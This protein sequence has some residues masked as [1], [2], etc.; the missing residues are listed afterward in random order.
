MP[1]KRLPP[2]VQVL[3]RDRA[4]KIVRG[5]RGWATV[6]DKRVFG[7]TRDTAEKAH[8]DA[9]KMRGAGVEA[10]VWTGALKTRAEEW[11]TSIAA[12]VSA[13]TVD[14]YRGKLKNIYRTIPESMPVDR[15]TSAI[16]R[17]FVREA[18]EK[19][20]LSARTI[21]HC[22]RT[23]NGLFTWMQRRGFLH[24]NPTV[25]VEWPKPVDT[26]PDALNEVELAAC[27]AKI[28]DPWARDLAVFMAFTGLRRSEVARL[29]LANVDLTNRVLWVHGKS[30]AQSHPIGDD[31]LKATT[32]LCA[33]AESREFLIPGT[34]LKSRREKIAETFRRWQKHLKEPRWHPHALRHS[35]G[36]IMLR[37]G[38]SPA[39]VQ[40]FLR[41]SSY[42]MT[43]RYVHMVEDDL[44]EATSRLRLLGDDER[45]QDHG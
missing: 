17:E 13:D 19:H 14:F 15:I 12:T 30:R 35:V 39:V 42:A 7:P 44:R 29:T 26:E 38:V 25:N 2:Y 27:L 20:R 1:R 41:H 45:E 32:A 33:A 28:T 36:T 31:A 22:R 43:Q 3:W 37:K 9:L 21:Q 23:L 11:L 4:R 10:T 24:D 6:G 18:R 5:Y 34:S 40:R 16:V 8:K